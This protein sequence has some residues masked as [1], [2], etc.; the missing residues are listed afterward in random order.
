MWEGIQFP[1]KAG[2][3][4]AKPHWGEAVHL[5]SVWEGILSVILPSVT[6]KRVHTRKNPFNCSVCGEGFNRPSKLL[7][8]QH[9]CTGE[10]PFTCSMC[11]KGFA[12]SSDLLTHQRVHTEDRP[13][14]CSDCEKTF[15]SKRDL[16]A[17]RVHTGERPFTC[18]IFG[19][20]FTPS[21]SLLMASSQVTAGA[22]VTAAVNHN[23]D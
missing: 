16:L 5:L 10:S 23:Q 14:K 19:K 1:I 20:G 18:S 15:K 6:H 11:G 17:H 8:H 3:S 2:N 4:S 9:I 22:A 12:N 7:T 13:F 21:P